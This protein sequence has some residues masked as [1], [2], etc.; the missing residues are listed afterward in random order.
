MAQEVSTTD[1]LR[2]A[3]S[4]ERRARLVVI[5]IGGAIGAGA[6]FAAYIYFGT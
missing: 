2:E 4:R 3:A 5:G 1:R 6:V